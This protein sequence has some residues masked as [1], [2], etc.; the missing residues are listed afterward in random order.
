MTLSNSDTREALGEVADA[1]EYLSE[2]K[3]SRGN[4]IITT[5]EGV[6]DSGGEL[7]RWQELKLEQKSHGITGLRRQ[8]E[9]KCIVNGRLICRYFADFVYYRDGRE[10]V[11]DWKGHREIVFNLKK[12]LVEALFDITITLTGAPA[13]ARKPKR[14]TEGCIQKIKKRQRRRRR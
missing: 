2:R 12:K 8:V 9:Y 4:R 5:S 7:A 11:E 10:I 3:G 13:R 6:F 14:L 1:I